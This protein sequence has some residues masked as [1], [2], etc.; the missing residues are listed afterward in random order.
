MI[1]NTKFQSIDYK[2]NH[3][4]KGF[5]VN[6][7]KGEEETTELSYSI[8]LPSEQAK[9]LLDDAEDFL[10]EEF[11][12]FAVRSQLNDGLFVRRGFS[13][14]SAHSLYFAFYVS[15]V[16]FCY[17]NLE[18]FLDGHFNLSFVGV[19]VHNEGVLLGLYAVVTFFGKHGSYDNIVSSHYTLASSIFS[20]A[21][22]VTTHLATLT[23]S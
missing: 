19:F 22:L 14:V 6:L 23:T 11:D 5:S 8:R 7:S 2:L 1:E 10:R 3:W 17:F 9:A 20:A 16:D 21:A 12:C 4:Y 13:L 18:D 15:G